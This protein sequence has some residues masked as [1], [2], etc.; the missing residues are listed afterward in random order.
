[1]PD[2]KSIGTSQT[3]IVNYDE[4]RSVLNLA[5]LDRVNIIYVSDETG[6]TTSNGFPIFPRMV[7]SLI[8][9]L[10]DEP[11]KAYYGV[12]SVASTLAHWSQYGDVPVT[13]D[14]EEDPQAPPGG[15]QAVIE[16]IR[17]GG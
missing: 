14:V 3:D 4:H 8:K 7:V 2:Q 16:R 1:M 15:I 5:N 6:V 9:L 10:G 13:P 12:A 11:E 17:M